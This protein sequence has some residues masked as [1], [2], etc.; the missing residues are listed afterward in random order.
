[1]GGQAAVLDPAI[2]RVF[3]NGQML[4]DGVDGHP[5]LGTDV[6]RFPFLFSAGRA[7]SQR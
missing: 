6:H 1:M 7:A 4:G 2:D 5:R 3:R